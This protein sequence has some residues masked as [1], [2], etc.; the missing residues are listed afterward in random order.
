MN[1]FTLIGRLFC[2]RE[3]TAG[4]VVLAM[5]CLAVCGI[6]GVGDALAAEI[7]ILKSS[8]ITAYDQAITGF[9][10][11]APSGALYSEYDLQGDLHR[12]EAAGECRHHGRG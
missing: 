3:H 2:G 7:A 4:R 5:A 11:T 6:W 1:V 12:R 10:S 9:K 8:S